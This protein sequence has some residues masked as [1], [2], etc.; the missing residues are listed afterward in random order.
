MLA[1]CYDNGGDRTATDRG[2][3]MTN[4]NPEA[5]FRRRAIDVMTNH[6]DLVSQ[7]LDKTEA[8]IARAA[9]AVEQQSQNVAVLTANVERLERAVTGL[10][11]NIALM[12]E[13]GRSQREMMNNLIKLATALVQQRAS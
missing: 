13:E 11:S 4:Q 8:T 7:R 5:Q 9:D 1:G 3:L 2:K 6:A 12:V 10:T